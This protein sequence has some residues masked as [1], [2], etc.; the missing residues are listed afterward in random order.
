MPIKSSKNASQLTDLQ[1]SIMDVIWARGTASVADVQTELSPSKR[2][3]RKT[4]ATIM[5]RLEKQGVLTHETAGREFVYRAVLS[6]ERVRKASVRSL[7]DKLFNGSAPALASYALEN[8]AVE[9]GD[10]E[11]A[12][13]LV[14][15]SRKKKG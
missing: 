15:K 3:A 10:V 9:R 13:A 6:K 2:L 12:A 1:L 8:S 5:T 4:I 11:K 7:I 14:K